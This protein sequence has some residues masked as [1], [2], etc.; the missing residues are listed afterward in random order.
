MKLPVNS[1]TRRKNA[2][3]TVAVGRQADKCYS[4]KSILTSQKDKLSVG[5]YRDRVLSEVP[6]EYLTWL[7]S[8]NILSPDRIT[9]LKELETKK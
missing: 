1:S 2:R 3:A 6:V 7:L 8:N 4:N 9:I 5:K